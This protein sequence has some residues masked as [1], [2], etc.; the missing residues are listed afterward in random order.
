MLRVQT[1]KKIGFLVPVLLLLSTGPLQA[2]PHAW[3]DLKTKLTFN[4]QGRLTGLRLHWVFD[5]FYSLYTIEAL[6]PDKDGKISKKKI[7]DLAKTNLN[8]L[9]EYD[10]FTEIKINGEVMEFG[11]VNESDSTF[12]D[13][14]L[15]MTFTLPLAKPVDP[16]GKKVSYVVFDPT[17]YIEVVHEREN[18]ISLSDKAPKN[19]HTVLREPTPTVEMTMLAAS[20]DKTENAGNTLGR[21]FAQT[22]SLT[23][24]E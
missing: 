6:D 16:I 11:K 8:N 7:M 2:H 1:V 21:V 10:Y 17:Y 23:C 19:C 4:D 5:D 24:A 3:I 18:A 15:S 14:R 22:V 13:N 12:A 20:L 9:V